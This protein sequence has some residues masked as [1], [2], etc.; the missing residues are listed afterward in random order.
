MVVLF[1]ATKIE[2]ASFVFVCIWI[3]E[4]LVNLEHN[5]IVIMICYVISPNKA[6]VVFGYKQ[7]PFRPVK[8]T[9]VE[10]ATSIC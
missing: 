2:E 8:K 3:P 10:F 1:A 9:D 7:K 6:Y 5:F 4:M